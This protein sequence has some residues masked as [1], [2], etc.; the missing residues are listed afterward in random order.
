[1]KIT[2]YLKGEF[3]TIKNIL[4]ALEISY[5]ATEDVKENGFTV[6]IIEITEKKNLNDIKMLIGCSM[7]LY[8]ER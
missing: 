8:N 5:N 6:D 7:K 2:F 3:E 1:M 4:D